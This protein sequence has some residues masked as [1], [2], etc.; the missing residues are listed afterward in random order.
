MR[1][2]RFSV[3]HPVT[4]CML[5]VL[6]FMGGSF[7]LLNMEVELLPSISIPTLVVFTENP[8]ASP[9]EIHKD[10]TLP[11]EE[12]FNSVGGLTSINSI[13]LEEQ[14]RIIMEFDWGRDVDLAEVEVR[15]QLNRIQ[16]PASAKK[17]LVWKYDPSSAPVFRFDIFSR[18]AGKALS[19]EEL[20]RVAEKTIK[21]RI[22]R[23]S[24]V[25]EVEIV[26]G[27][28]PE[29]RI[30]GRPA[31]L[32][33]YN[34]T[35]LALVNAVQK[36][37]RNRKGGSMA[38]D[39]G[40]QV[41][42]RIL[43]KARNIEDLE[44]VV[45]TTLKPGTYI[46]VKDVADVQ[47]A[48]KKAESKARING[49]DSVGISIKKTSDS[50]VVTVVEEIKAELAAL[51]TMPALDGVAMQISQDD[52]EYVINAQN[53]VIGSI[54]QGVLLAAILLVLFL[55]DMRATV[56]VALS[57]PT[58]IIAAFMCLK[59]LDLSRN[60][61]TLG[62]MGLAAGMTLDS[63]IVLLDSIY[64]QLELGKQPKDAAINGASEVAAGIFSSNMT[65][66]AVFLPI[67][68]IPGL[69]R[70]IFKDLS[71]AI[72]WAV[73]FSMV[74]GILFIPMVSARILKPKDPEKK[75]ELPAILRICLS[76]WTLM[77]R[78]MEGFDRVSESILG[79]IL[80]FFLARK[81]LKVFTI[82]GL[83]TISGLSLYFAPGH[84]FLPQGQVNE[85]WVK[86]EAPLGSTLKYTDDRIRLVEEML[87]KEPYKQFVES[88]AADVKADEAR[89][90]VRLKPNKNI[91]LRDAQ[92]R[93]VFDKDG[94]P[95]YQEQR[96]GKWY[97]LA[98]CVQKIRDGCNDMLDLKGQTFVTVVDKVRGGDSA[99][100]TLKIYR[101]RGGGRGTESDRLQ[102]LQALVRDTIVPAVADLPGATYQRLAL[103]ET[104]Q[105]VL[106]DTS[107]RRTVLSERGVTTQS[108]S[109]TVRASIYGVQVETV[110]ETDR[111][112]DVSVIL[113]SSNQTGA[114]YP[115]F[116]M[117]AVR[118]LRVRSGATGQLHAIGTM[119]DVSDVP[120]KGSVVLERTNRKTTATL[121]SHTQ[122]YEISGRTVGDVSAGIQ[123]TLH[124]MPGFSENYTYDL[125]NVAKD[126]EESFADAAKAF[127]I[128]V[129]LIYMIMC[130][131]FERFGDPLAIMVTVPLAAIGSIAA[132]HGTGEITSL[133]ALVGA[134]ILCGVVVNNGIIL[135]EYINILR[136][137]GES[138]NEAIV[139]GSVRKIRSILITSLTSILGMLPL[140]L[141]VGEGTELYRGVAAV[142][143]GGLTV[144]TP[145]TLVVLPLLYSVID[146]TLDFVGTLA[147]RISTL[148]GVK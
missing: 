140:M 26:G 135:V 39:G 93:R 76:P 22:E 118:P 60:V 86:F 79:A 127:A 18:D 66:V 14:S 137:R 72:I 3:N 63:S 34:L 139:Q 44:N 11:L 1:I 126:T 4:T 38:I 29:Y 31:D 17:P 83:I 81:V 53:M 124:A 114:A 52:S 119:A 94:N 20:R 45:V 27:A 80:R 144:S 28:E 33:R 2:I 84:A 23:I 10:I 143:V 19:P 125:K 132:L 43:G 142:I 130:A 112:V 42:L 88:A 113:G 147:F 108:I 13:S 37:A 123:A 56:V 138:R 105:E 7:A 68:F 12:A 54:L 116:V 64:K 61:L 97:S 133:S 70:E 75:L 115:E 73:L 95:V 87:Q 8:K 6:F 67:L 69:M 96:K 129:I 78:I 48:K 145:L 46:R 40:R 15:E 134:V 136:A 107:G 122:P 91:Q 111:E 99:P 120:R 41:S 103:D 71:Y 92:G 109:D 9:E 24:G 101:K 106:I 100:I 82:A 62:G 141:G 117:T 65:T 90:F 77:C 59:G 5:L 36:E 57:T 128:S 131:Q 32:A 35:V 25:G 98:A 146:D 30:T 110:Q 47:R 102:S 16:L 148:M 55:R 50:S 89:L 85:L 74:I 51:A 104:P 121:E 21:L 49:S 58:S